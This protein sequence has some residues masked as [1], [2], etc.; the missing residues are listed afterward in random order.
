M[1]F[2]VSKLF[3]F[4]LNPVNWVFACLVF[5]FIVRSPKIRRYI[6]WIGIGLFL[7]FSN[8]P[9]QRACLLAW[10]PPVAYAQH[11][12]TY[13]MGIMLTGMTMSDKKRQIFFGST[14]DRFI[15]TS[16]LYHTGV[17][18]KIFISG[19]DG[20]LLQQRPGEAEFLRREFVAQGIPDSVLFIE[21]KSRN[22]YESAVA[23]KR[24]VDSL[25]VQ[26]TIVLITSAV[27][28]RRASQTFSK[29]AI[30][31][32][33]HPTNFEVLENR[34]GLTDFIIPDI[35]TLFGWKYLLKEMTGLIAYRITGKA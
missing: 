17:I 6:K 2:I 12:R 8:N 20:S 35:G 16:K 15:Q 31:L 3:Y 22:T 19:G 29:A 25:H 23:A 7:L 1:F 11:H 13:P 10:Q 24:M 30:P 27:H 14:A 26:D 32:T 18:R 28:M 33:P 34:P 5:Y 4:L 9:L 21:K